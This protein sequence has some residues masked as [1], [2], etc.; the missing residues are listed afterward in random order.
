MSQ[1]HE[2]K[3][4]AR[5][6]LAEPRGL[7][8]RAIFWFVAREFGRTPRS[9]RVGARWPRLFRATIWMELALEAGSSIPVRTKKLA[10]LAA[11]RTIGCRYCMDIGSW[12]A[13]NSGVKTSDLAAFDDYERAPCFSESER[14]A[15]ALSE[16]MSATPPEVD[17]ALFARVR[18]HFS[19]AQIVELASVVAWEQYRARLNHTLGLA[20]D[21][22]LDTDSCPMPQPAV[23]PISA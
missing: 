22:F 1:P 11:A 6:A 14:A 13:L 7:F 23:S 8:Q 3:A 5:I 17:E 12:V 15:I 10:D 19:E 20:P 18:A 2:S 9:M 4:P 16:A 21:G